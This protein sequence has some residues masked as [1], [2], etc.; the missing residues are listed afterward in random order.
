MLRGIPYQR[1]QLREEEMALAVVKS[2]PIIQCKV[3]SNPLQGP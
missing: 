3:S 1:E 2:H